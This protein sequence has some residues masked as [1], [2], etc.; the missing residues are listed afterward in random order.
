MGV[1]YKARDTELSRFVALKALPPDHLDRPNRRLRFLQEARSASALSH[2]HIV[3]VHDILEAEGTD[4]IVMEYVDGRTL[5][6]LLPEGGLPLAQA[7]RWAADVADALAAAHRA[8]IVHRDVKPGNLMV[9]GE[10]RIRVLDFGLAKLL[11]TDATPTQVTLAAPKT[12]L[13]AVL[14]T[15]DYMS[16]EQALGKPADE[17]S[18]IFSLGAVLYEMV[19]GRRPFARSSDA[20]MLHAVAFEQAE[21]P[22]SVRPDTP[23]EV[24]D[25]LATALAKDPAERFAS[26]AEMAA[27]LR[28]A[29][30]APEGR[31][32]R[33]PRRRRAVGGASGRRR[34]PL[35]SAAG[36]ALAAGAAILVFL[37]F[38]RPAPPAGDR[39][40]PA[41]APAADAELPTTPFGLY[42]R[43]QGLLSH[44]WRSG[45]VDRAIELLQ[46]AVEMDP[47]Y[48]PAYAALADGYLRKYVTERDKVW[49][50]RALGQ[51]EHALSLDPSLTAAH[52]RLGQVLLTRGERERA[53]AEF[54]EVE[55]RD[56]AN[57]AAYR[58]LGDVA[59]AGG[60]PHTAEELYTQAIAKAPDDPELYSVLGTFLFGAG[61]YAAAAEAF[62]K[63]TAVAPDYVF[64]YRNRAGAL[65]MLGRYSDAAAELQRALVI[66]PDAA[67]YSNLG[68]L[69]FFQALYPQALKAYQQAVKLGANDYRIWSNL[70]D[71]YR[72]TS[73][74]E[75]DARRAYQRALQLLDQEAGGRRPTRWSPAAGPCCSPSRERT[76]RPSPWPA[77]RR[78]GPRT[79]P[80]STAVRSPTSW[81]ETAR[82]PWRPWPRRWTTVTRPRRSAR[83]PSSPPCARTPTTT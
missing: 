54:R 10:G 55:K 18:D 83:I 12:R 20:S 46:R 69:Y 36:A 71:A 61:R 74:H 24:S 64:A 75:E 53:A 48:A 1:V 76:R 60:D 47:G 19:T 72:W 73:G 32:R 62:G 37:A 13:G 70:G 25:L 57:A 3:T 56:P 78:P 33:R 11:L 16:P 22:E 29:Q 6:E 8:G 45:Y 77:R 14:G 35:W 66:R 50:E 17:R 39:G 9:D 34:W 52:L 79:R 81:R 82:G 43:G 38:G 4:W 15:L 7:L 44:Y 23:S 42:E 21:P 27:A 80:P 51:A 5:A 2:P 26:M 31:G 41:D 68:T 65:H 58:G 49:L 40:A 59:A 63:A 28:A 30:A 67:T